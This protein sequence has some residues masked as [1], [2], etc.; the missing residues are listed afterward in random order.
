MQHL[1][2][3]LN[4]QSVLNTRF[5]IVIKI[6]YKHSHWVYAPQKALDNSEQILLGK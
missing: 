3:N 4:L 6:W 1:M 2:F 5:P